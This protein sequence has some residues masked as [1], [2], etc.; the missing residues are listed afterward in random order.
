[1]SR[2]LSPTLFPGLFS[3]LTQKPRKGPENEVEAW[4]RWL[5]REA[6][7]NKRVKSKFSKCPDSQIRRYFGTGDK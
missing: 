3:H 7:K 1:M 6:M 5:S 4:Y 2:K